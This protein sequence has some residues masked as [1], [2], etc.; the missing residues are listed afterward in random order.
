MLRTRGFLR[1]SWIF[2]VLP[3][4]L[5]STLPA[6]AQTL[7]PMGG[8]GG[9]RASLSGTLRDANTHSPLEGA[10]VDMRS[11][12]GSVINTV[13][14]N[15]TGTFQ[16]DGLS[17]GN[18]T[19]FFTLDGYEQLQQ[20][21]QVEGGPVMGLD[22]TLRRLDASDAKNGKSNTISAHEL[23]VP[24]KARDAMDKGMRLLYEKSDY[25]GAIGQFEQA[26]KID[27]DYYEASMQMGIAYTKLG[28]NAGAEQ[29]LHKTLT[30]NPNYPDAYSAFALLLC[31]EK[32]FE[33]AE[34]AARKA[35]ELA[36]SS[37]QA[38]YELGR[39]L[40][41]LDRSGEAEPSVQ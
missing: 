28:D 26:L 1:H 7:G 31:N 11:P 2:A 23:A 14:T 12:G 21:V 35:V 29:I 24:G 15:S 3:L 22:L 6:S 40:Y 27:P 4:L 33:D 8:R 32:K 9:R 25:K 13:F 41:G 18:Y 37:W 39:A 20:E 16:F 30:I 10:K 38:H 17:N 36:P 19:L 5:A 34:P